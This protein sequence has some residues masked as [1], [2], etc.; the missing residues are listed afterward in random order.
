MTSPRDLTREIRPRRNESDGGIFR[1][2]RLRGVIVRGAIAL[3]PT[4]PSV[5]LYRRDQCDTPTVLEPCP[6]IATLPFDIEALPLPDVVADALAPAPLAAPPSVPPPVADAVLPRALFVELAV[7][8]AAPP[9]PVAVLCT[10]PAVSVV[11]LSAPLT[12]PAPL[13]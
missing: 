10:P 5:A 2:R 8:L 12:L 9:A 13:A 11:P 4:R 6:D 1:P 7:L 3:S